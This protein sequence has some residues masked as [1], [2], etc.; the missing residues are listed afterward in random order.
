M[1]YLSEIENTA[2]FIHINM[3]QIIDLGYT[4]FYV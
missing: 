2:T 3:A 1:L 4:L